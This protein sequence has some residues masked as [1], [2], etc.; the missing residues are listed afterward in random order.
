MDLLVSA[1]DK[2][3]Q[4]YGIFSISTNSSVCLYTQKYSPAELQGCTFISDSVAYLI[5]PVSVAKSSVIV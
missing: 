5:E 1:Y 2:C 4:R 3:M